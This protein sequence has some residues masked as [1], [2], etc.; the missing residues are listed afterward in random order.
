MTGVRRNPSPEKLAFANKL[1]AKDTRY[2]KRLW[3]RLR[4]GI[5]GIYCSQQVVVRG[6]VV[7]FYFPKVRI[8]VELDGKGHNLQHDSARD[9][10][11]LQAG[12]TVLRFRNPLTQVDV[13][14]IVNKVWRECRYRLTAGISTNSQHSSQQQQVKREGDCKTKNCGNVENVPAWKPSLENLGCQRQVFDSLEVAGN[15]VR[16]LRNL[17][18]DATVERCP[19]CKLIHL[20][21][22]RVTK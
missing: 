2:E 21:E 12:V 20:T 14:T 9:S 22:Q 16:T 15:F 13:N 18:I 3:N 5:R 8:A 6:Y 1:R 4:R 17:G 7:D 11:L 19:S 10:H